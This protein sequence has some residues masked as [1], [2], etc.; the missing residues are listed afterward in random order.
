MSTSNL[1]SKKIQLA[2]DGSENAELVTRP[3]VE[4][5][6]GTGSELHVL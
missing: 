4:L 2:S 1:L 3:T 6:E 5:T